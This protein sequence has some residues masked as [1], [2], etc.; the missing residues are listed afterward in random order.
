[1][2]R[3][4]VR[5]AEGPV[6]LIVD[7]PTIDVRGVALLAHPHPLLGGIPK[8]KVPATLANRAPK[9]GSWP[10]PAF[11]GVGASAGVHDFGGGE[12]LDL[13]EIARQCRERYRALTLVLVGYSFG[14][15]VQ[16]PVWWQLDAIGASPDQLALIGSGAGELAGGRTLQTGT[17]AQ[18]D[19]A[20]PRAEG[21]VARQCVAVGRAS[22]HR[23]RDYSGRGPRV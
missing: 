23:C 17:L 6:E 13:C 5:G 2:F 4:A 15:Y 7:Q 9:F 18:H 21:R 12:A 20:G 11:R 3:G 22:W 19:H 10:Y 8:H 16:A 1:M 14:A